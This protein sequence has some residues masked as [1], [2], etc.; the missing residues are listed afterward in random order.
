MQVRSTKISMKTH[1]SPQMLRAQQKHSRRQMLHDLCNGKKTKKIRGKRLKTKTA[2][3][4]FE[5]YTEFTGFGKAPVSKHAFLPSSP[6][7]AKEPSEPCRFR[8]AAVIY[9]VQKADSVKLCA[10]VLFF[11]L[12][13]FSPCAHQFVLASTFMLVH[14]F[15]SFFS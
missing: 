1:H 15:M 10:V 5:K 11:F 9:N 7:V 13:R 4:G 12:F 8:C 6:S 14:L 2:K 3:R